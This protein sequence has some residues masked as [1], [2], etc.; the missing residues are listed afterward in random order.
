MNYILNKAIL[1]RVKKNKGKPNKITT[2]RLTKIKKTILK[3]SSKSFLKKE[4]T[5]ETLQIKKR[6]TNK[7]KHPPVLQSSP[8]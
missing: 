8:G 7:T 4:R 2:L 3:S 5:L 1:P 6:Q